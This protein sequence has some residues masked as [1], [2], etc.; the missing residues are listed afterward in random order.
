MKNILSIL[1]ALFLFSSAVASGAASSKEMTG[2]WQG[3]LTAGQTKLRVV[4]NINQSANGGLTATMDSL[5]QNARGIPVDSVTLTGTSLSISV[6]AV[7]GLYQGTMDAAGK[8]IT[9]QWS[10]GPNTLPLN[11]VKGTGTEAASPTEALSPADLEASKE[12][13]QKMAGTWNG[14]LATGGPVLH[15]RINLTKTANGTATGTM[16]SLD[17]GA[18]G[19]PL[20]A[21]ALKTGKVR[22]EVPGVGGVYEATLAADGAT[23]TGHWQQNGQ[24]LPL[25]F[26]KAKTE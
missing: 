21:I 2:S 24:T 20:S 1:T 26:Q 17:Q 13:V 8:A 4:F 9:G 16:D 5:D 11:L 15:L 23:L 22:F 10:Q 19:L 25:D 14:A 7:Q 6:K 12:V 18:N 3:T